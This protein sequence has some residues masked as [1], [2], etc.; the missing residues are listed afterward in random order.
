MTTFIPQ[1]PFSRA[2]VTIAVVLASSLTA[3]G[4]GSDSKST[5][6]SKPPANQ[7]ETGGNMATN[8]QQLAAAALATIATADGTIADD[9]SSNAASQ[10][11]AA[12]IS[13]L[14]NSV[15]ILAVTTV[16]QF[17]GADP[18]VDTGAGNVTTVTDDKDPAGPST[19]DTVTVTFNACQRGTVTINGTRG[20]T[21]VSLTGTPFVTPPWNVETKRDSDMTVATNTGITF[22]NKGTSTISEASTDGVTVTRHVIGT[23]DSSRT[24][25]TAAT[26]TSDKFDIVR[27]SNQNTQTFT[28]EA[29][30]GSTGT[31][32]SHSVTT[33]TPLSGTRGS[34]PEAGVILIAHTD[35]AGAK[36]STKLT[37]QA[38]GLV[39]VEVDSNGDGT[40]DSTQTTT[41]TDLI[42]LGVGP[43][44]GTGIGSGGGGGFGS[45]FNGGGGGTAPPGTGVP[46][47]TG[48]GAPGGGFGP[49][50]GT[51]GAPG[52]GFG[53]GTGT[54]GAPGGGFGPGTGTGGAPGGGFGPGT[55][56]GGGFGGGAPGT[57][58]PPPGAVP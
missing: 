51:G 9:P 34:P 15:G 11:F 57:V 39:L 8:S 1:R 58:S 31:A 29:T 28:L 6:T 54:G 44:F 42:G 10:E 27:T 20:H 23:F 50:T 16:V 47:G 22:T 19:G 3:C 40:I 53:P 7:T 30:I 33:P 49:G 17:C 13:N 32:G 12:P 46:P 45:G 14:G 52:G 36:S 55:G 18:A 43:I 5:S 41:W 2:G 38:G 56:T 48:T 4:G 25:A 24:T 26:T 35:L 21:V 37:A